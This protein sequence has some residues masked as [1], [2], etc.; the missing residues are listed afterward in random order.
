M[1]APWFVLQPIISAFIS[2]R[3]KS[4]Q[5]AIVYNDVKGMHN[6]ESLNLLRMHPGSYIERRSGGIYVINDVNSQSLLP[7]NPDHLRIEDILREYRIRSGPTLI[8]ADSIPPRPRIRRMSVAKLL[9]RQLLEQS[10]PHGGQNNKNHGT[11]FPST[12]FLRLGLKKHYPLGLNK[13]IV[14]ATVINRNPIQIGPGQNH[15]DCHQSLGRWKWEVAK[16]TG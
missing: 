13:T 10:L 3:T 12:R 6:T 14:S 4:L 8:D 7:F 2:S 1:T 9:A 16:E 11:E 15:K 5:T